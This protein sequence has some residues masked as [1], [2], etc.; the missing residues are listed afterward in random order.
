M[1]RNEAV[2]I[3]VLVVV[4]YLVVVFVK[5]FVTYSRIARVFGHCTAVSP[6]V[7]CAWSMPRGKIVKKIVMLENPDSVRVVA[8]LRLF[9]GTEKT[10]VSEAGARLKLAEL[11]SAA[12]KLEYDFVRGEVGVM[13]DSWRGAL[14]ELK[15]AIVCVSPPLLALNAGLSV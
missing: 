14:I 1:R 8:K 2:L 5:D 9:E 4:V 15:K 10:I 11:L 6:G 12:T 7:G 13:S 3:A